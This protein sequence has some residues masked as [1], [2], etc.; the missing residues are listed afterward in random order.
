V[1]AIIIGFYLFVGA[2]LYIIDIEEGHIDFR[3][4]EACI[5]AIFW[6]PV[7]IFTMIR[8]GPND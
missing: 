6:L 5:S 2:G 7:M 1:Y 8:G 3:L 4:V